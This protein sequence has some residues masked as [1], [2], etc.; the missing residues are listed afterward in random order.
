MSY[1]VVWRPK[2][3]TNLAEAWLA[4]KDRLAVTRAAHEIDRQL[5]HDPQRAGESRIGTVRILIEE[6]LAALYEV[7]E[8]DR[9][10]FVLSVWQS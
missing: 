10:V 2:A 4:S 7:V 5:Q 3:E 6:P 9:R 1:S 8:D